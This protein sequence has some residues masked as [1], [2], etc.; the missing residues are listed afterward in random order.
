MQGSD[1]RYLWW[2]DAL[3]M[4]YRAIKRGSADLVL[5]GGTESPLHPSALH[6][7]ATHPAF[8]GRSDSDR[9]RPFDQRANSFVLAEGAGICVLEEYEHALRRGATIYGEI[10]GYAQAYASGTIA[11]SATFSDGG[12]N[13][14][15]TGI[16]TY[17][18]IVQQALREAELSPQ[19]IA[20][21]FPMVERWRRGILWRRRLYTRCLVASGKHCSVAFP[22]HN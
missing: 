2:A 22:V 21:V 17:I 4:A 10:V 9:Y 3:G 11:D 18:H 1:Q 12:I 15:Q 20:C 16:R 19:D 8:G 14:I 7:L 5:A 13:S 6:V